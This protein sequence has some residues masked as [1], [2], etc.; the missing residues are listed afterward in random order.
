MYTNSLVSILQEEQSE[1]ESLIKG[2]QR[3]LKKQV[4]G[5][6]FVRNVDGRQYLYR[7]YSQKGKIKQEYIKR[8]SPEE[9]EKVNQLMNEVRKKR[10]LLREAKSRYI[11]IQKA[12]RHA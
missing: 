11:F 7:T 1:L 9:A 6:L 4:D 10:K 2:Y 3:D 12:L 5:C 8:V